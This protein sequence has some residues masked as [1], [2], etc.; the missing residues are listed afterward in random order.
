MVTLLR[1]ARTSSW[2]NSAKDFIAKH[3]HGAVVDLQGIIKSNFLF[4]KSESFSALFSFAKVLNQCNQ[5]FNDLCSL[6]GPILVT[7][8][9][10]R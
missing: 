5:F 4:R 1:T 2:A 10:V 3:L 8:D 6:D 7:P 9:G